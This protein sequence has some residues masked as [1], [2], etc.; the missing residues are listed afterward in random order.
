MATTWGVEVETL[1]GPREPPLKIAFPCGWK[2]GETIVALYPYRL[3]GGHW[4]MDCCV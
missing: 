2:E 4:R 1:D 3:R